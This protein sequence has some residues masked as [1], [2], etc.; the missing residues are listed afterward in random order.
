MHRNNCRCA[1]DGALQERGAR[2][3]IRGAGLYRGLQSPPPP[4]RG[5]ET[6]P[7]HNHKPIRVLAVG[8]SPI[9]HDRRRAHT[10]PQGAS[11]NPMASGIYPADGLKHQF[12]TARRVGG[13]GGR[14]CAGDAPT[15]STRTGL[16]LRTG[17]SLRPAA[18]G[19]GAGS[20]LGRR[21]RG[22]PRP[23]TIGAAR[24][25]GVQAPPRGSR[26]LET[27]SQQPN[28][29]LPDAPGG[30]A[31]R[32]TGVRSEGRTTSARPTTSGGAVTT[33]PSPRN[34]P[35]AARNV[36]EVQRK[37]PEVARNVPEH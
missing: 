28:I 17:A 4:G 1:D 35:G 12:R 15:A 26:R 14:W 10:N 20:G 2:G 6:P 37:T 19:T 16:W 25:R 22:C 3:G 24:W 33:P 23:A 7:V 36:P 8:A 9:Y 13:V 27:G 32:T 34:V 21:R 30:L 5:V 11:A 29:G 31:I 18:D